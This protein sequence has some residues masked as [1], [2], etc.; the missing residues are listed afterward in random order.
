[1]YFLHEQPPGAE[2]VGDSTMDNLGKDWRV[3]TVEGQKKRFVPGT[4]G[5][6]DGE[7]VKRKVKFLTHAEMIAE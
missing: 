6:S 4:K 2:D 1:M 3:Y 5:D 7:V